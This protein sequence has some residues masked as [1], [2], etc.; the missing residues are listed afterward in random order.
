MSSSKLSFFSE[1]PF[2]LAGPGI[3]RTVLNSQFKIE[4]FGK[5]DVGITFVGH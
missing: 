3:L 5:S 1:C 4:I 2:Y